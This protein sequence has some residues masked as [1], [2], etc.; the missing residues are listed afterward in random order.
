MR[1]LIQKHYEAFFE[2]AAIPV[3]AYEPDQSV[4]SNFLTSTDATVPGSKQL[5][6]TATP[7]GF[8]RGW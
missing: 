6:V 4:P 5:T 7:S 3:A 2:Q 8:D 1:L